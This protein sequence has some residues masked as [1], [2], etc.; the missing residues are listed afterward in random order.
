MYSISVIC[1]CVC[2][3]IFVSMYAEVRLSCMNL[4]VDTPLVHECSILPHNPHIPAEPCGSVRQTLWWSN[5][6]VK[7]RKKERKANVIK[8]WFIK[9][10]GEIWSSSWQGWRTGAAWDSWSE[11]RKKHWDGCGHLPLN[12]RGLHPQPLLAVF[13][14]FSVRVSRLIKIFHRWKESTAEIKVASHKWQSHAGK[15]C[16]S[17]KK[18][19]VLSWRNP[20]A[21]CAKK[22]KLFPV[23]SQFLRKKK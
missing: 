11:C 23:I 5:C 13:F 12:P 10:L 22:K 8:L 1:V 14:F 7:K 17:R 9:W 19:S 2:A 15:I 20:L 18:K 4:R 21:L 3:C 6:R 16:S